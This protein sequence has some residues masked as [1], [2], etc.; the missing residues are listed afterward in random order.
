MGAT[1][2]SSVLA[3]ALGGAIATLV[4]LHIVVV[5]VLRIWLGR[6]YVYGLA[7]LFDMA[8]EGNIPAWFTSAL[9]M[10]ASIG[11][12]IA[13]RF[14]PAGDG[15][16]K[17]YW[18]ALA[19]LMLFL[20]ADESIRIHEKLGWLFMRGQGRGIFFYGWP[21]VYG[22]IV[23]ALGLWMLRFLTLL[24]RRTG[25]L[26]AFS[27]FIYVAGALGMEM[28]ESSMAYAKFNEPASQVSAARIDSLETDVGYQIAVTVEES[29]EM[30]G[31][32][33]FLFALA[34][35]VEQRNSPAPAWRIQPIGALTQA[36]GRVEPSSPARRADSL[37]R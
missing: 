14:S 11:C 26:F 3:R 17:K 13:S 24:P 5:F 32:A 21:I 10:A 23:L 22:P 9:M 30:A 37:E 33:L 31:L 34:G 1:V 36:A 12:V 16:L 6:D 29:L 8:Q 18:A 27:G 4:G 19:F 35:Y 7:D 15:R 28:L 20:S 25:L 2:Q